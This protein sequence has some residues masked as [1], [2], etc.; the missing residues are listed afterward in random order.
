MTPT[1]LWNKNFTL[2]WLGTAQS[3]FGDALHS[4]AMAFLVLDLTGSATSMGLNLALAMFPSLLSPLAGNWMD[5]IPLKPPLVI[6]DLLRGLLG[7][8]VFVLASQ[9]KL[10][11]P[12]IYT[13]TVLFSLL[14]VMYRP[15]AGKIFPELVP[16]H[17]LARANGLL[18]TATQTMQLLGLVGGGVLIGL[19][20]TAQAIL[21]DAISFLIMAGVFVL[22]EL[23][24]TTPDHQEPFWTGMKKGLQVIRSSQL[25]LLVTGMAFLLNAAVAPTEVLAP[26]IMQDLGLGARGYG[27]WMGTFMGGMVLGS[28]LVTV[29]GNK[30]KPQQVIFWGLTSMGFCLLGMAPHGQVWIMFVAAGLMGT[31]VAFVN[32]FIG[33]LLQGSVEAR[34]RGRVFGV[35]GSVGQLGMPLMVLAVSGV[36]DQISPVLV[37]SVAAGVTLLMAVVWLLRVG[38][39]EKSTQLPAS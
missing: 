5:R 1:R 31:G 7:L 35:L 8:T 25:L 32:T 18:G 21:I 26:K 28:V 22:I 9:G 23:P 27:F 30:M 4:L 38:Q 36:A 19:L 17:E 10:G 33:V 11:L 12:M 24:K 37:Y 13:F 20:G 15:A 14:G 29:L 34:Y 16:R 3:N 2:Y 6:G 39:Q